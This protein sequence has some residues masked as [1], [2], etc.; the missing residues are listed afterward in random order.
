MTKPTCKSIRWCAV[1]CLALLAALAPMAECPAAAPQRQDSGAS[2]EDPPMQS[3]E[4][5]PSAPSADEIKPANLPAMDYL[6]HRVQLP[7]SDEQQRHLR[8]FEGK[9][10]HKAIAFSADGQTGWAAGYHDIPLAKRTALTWCLD[11][12]LEP[13]YL[14]EVDDENVL[15]EFDRFILESRSALDSLRAPEAVAYSEEADDWSVPQQQSLRTYAEGEEAPTPTSIP[16]ATTVATREAVA[17]LRERAAVPIYAAGWNDEALALLPGSLLVD[18]IAWDALDATGYGDVTNAKLEKRLSETMAQLV[19]DRATPLLIYCD[20]ARCWDSY[21]TVLRLARLGYRELYWYRGGLPAWKAAGLPL[22]KGVF[23]TT[24]MTAAKER[25]AYVRPQDR[26]KPLLPA[27]GLWS[28]SYPS[29]PQIPPIRY[30]SDGVTP[31]NIFGIDREELRE[32]LSCR[33]GPIRIDHGVTRSGASCHFD[34]V[35]WTVETTLRGD[36][37]RSFEVELDVLDSAL[38]PV[39]P[40]L[41]HQKMKARRIGACPAKLPANSYMMPDGTVVPGAPFPVESTVTFH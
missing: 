34:G 6:R 31:S 35:I 32:S 1:T 36:L 25:V 7:L 33:A 27:A 26:P 19:P 8:D 14:Y 22:I 5:A 40:A 29:L 13:C 21:N 38:A 37:A 17:L 9:E 11:H 24:I 30:C 39:P 16:G 10:G 2:I 20:G 23:N 4:P 3:G 12:T 15:G 28:F 18:W 41:V